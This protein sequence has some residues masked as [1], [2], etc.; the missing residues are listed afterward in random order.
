MGRV[1]SFAQHKGGCGKTTVAAHVVGHAVANGRS[2]CVA[3]ADHQHHLATWIEGALPDVHV[4]RFDDEEQV[5]KNI[6][7]LADGADNPDLKQPEGICIL[8]LPG[9]DQNL[10]RA[11]MLRSDLVVIPVGPGVLDLQ[12]LQSTLETLELAR[13][14]RGGS[15]PLAVIVPTRTKR[16]RVSQEVIDACN[17]IA[18]NMDGVLV[19]TG[20]P[21]RTKIA[22]CYAQRCFAWDLE[23]SSTDP[24]LTGPLNEVAAWIL[25]TDGTFP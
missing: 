8:D 17:E 7:K 13:D 15:A 10:M 14:I 19:V 5:L 4:E 6:R 12:S 23:G 21:D 3:D 25:R 18:A 20:I 1:I 9:G 24:A 11:A 16:T 22:D 2:V